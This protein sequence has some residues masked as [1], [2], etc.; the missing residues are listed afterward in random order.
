[1]SILRYLRARDWKLEKAEKMIKASLDW[2]REWQVEDI[3]R[4]DVILTIVRDSSTIRT[5]SRLIQSP[6]S[7]TADPLATWNSSLFCSMLLALQ[8]DTCLLTQLA[9]E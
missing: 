6:S 8:S 9:F 2:R 4:E 3:Q 5:F 7:R 1:M